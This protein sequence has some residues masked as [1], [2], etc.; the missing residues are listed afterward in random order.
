MGSEK[1]R[2][3][4]PIKEEADDVGH[5]EAGLGHVVRIKAVP[6]VSVCHPAKRNTHSKSTSLYLSH[7]TTPVSCLSYR[8]RDLSSYDK[9][10]LVW[11]CLCLCITGF[12][13]LP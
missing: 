6:V 7:G 2:G 11:S 13:S 5:R 4:D 8:W 9:D 1:E 3:V 12:V 10:V